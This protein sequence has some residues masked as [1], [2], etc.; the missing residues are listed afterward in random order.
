M[1][2]KILLA[3]ASAAVLG[4]TGQAQAA[5]AEFNLDWSHAAFSITSGSGSVLSLGNGVD[6]TTQVF[7]M[8]DALYQNGFPS[9]QTQIGANYAS[10]SAGTARAAIV[11]NGFSNVYANSSNAA[12]IDIAANGHAV[13]H[14][15]YAYS[16]NTTM[17]G[18]QDATVSYTFTTG[19]DTPLGV[20]SNTFSVGAGQQQSGQ[21]LIDIL[22]D[23]TSNQTLRF[24]LT[25]DISATTTA[26]PEPQTYGMLLGGLALLG[27]VARRKK[28]AAAARGH[29]PSL[30]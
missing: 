28:R 23:N 8:H 9:L 15:P 16:V 25:Q 19:G 4:V 5:T 2:K 17:A 27:L 26:V 1:F 6:V 3:A 24:S 12:V 10:A 29:H 7:T 21:G 14:V 11:E 30:I 13:L 18:D 20:Y 22:L